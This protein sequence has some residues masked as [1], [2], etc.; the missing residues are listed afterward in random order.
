MTLRHSLWA[1]IKKG[2][3][4]NGIFW[5]Q[6]TTDK[7]D[8]QYWRTF[9]TFAAW[10]TWQCLFQTSVNRSGCQHQWTDHTTCGNGIP[11]CT[12]HQNSKYRQGR[13]FVSVSS[14]YVLPFNAVPLKTLLQSSELRNVCNVWTQFLNH[15]LKHT[16]SKRRKEVYSVS[17]TD[18]I[19]SSEWGE[20]TLHQCGGYI[21]GFNF[22][23]PNTLRK[24][25][26][27]VSLF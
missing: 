22:K 21:E 13:S 15:R 7:D 20:H 11:C 27:M 23:L 9:T 26:L 24:I 18:R 2:F 12:S 16:W 1:A 25:T 4:V 17:Q 5:S 6:L 10:M 19:G 3:V 14:I 8:S